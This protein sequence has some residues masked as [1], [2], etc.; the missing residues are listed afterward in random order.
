VSEVGPGRHGQEALVRA[1]LA[2]WRDG[3]VNLT[4]TNRLLNFTQRKTSTVPI[5]GPSLAA[6]VSDLRAD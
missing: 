4:G 1:A 3:L 6:V 5:A 2:S